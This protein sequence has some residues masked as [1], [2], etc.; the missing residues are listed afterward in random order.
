MRERAASI[1]ASLNISSRPG[2]G[3]EIEVSVPGRLAY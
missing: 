3:T 2:A 1:G